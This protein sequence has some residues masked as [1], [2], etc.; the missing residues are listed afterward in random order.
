MIS[1]SLD[2]TVMLPG[3]ILPYESVVL[4]ARTAG[5][6]EQVLVDRGSVVKKGQLLVKLSAPE[7]AA[8]VAEAESKVQ[9][10]DSQRAEAEAQLASAQS[11]YDKLKTAAAT[12]GAIAGN[13]LVQAE[14]TVDAAKALARSREG[15]VRAA[16]ALVRAAKSMEEYL[17]LTAPFS[18]VITQRFVHPG[19]LVG[20]GTAEGLLELQQVSRL[21]LVVAVPEANATAIARG[22]RVQF[23]VPASPGQTFSGV[24]A[25]ISRALDPKTRTM[26]VELDVQNGRGLLAPGMYPQV[27]WPVHTQGAVLLVPST[28]V[29]TTTER[30]F[31]IRVRNGRAEWVNV[32]RG[33]AAGDLVQVLGTVQAGDLVVRRGTD[34][35]REGS[36]I[37][38]RAAQSYNVK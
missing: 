33:A 14:K 38:A 19:A 8:Q 20:P 30:T 6:V 5:Y 26:P 7:M 10:A 22:G 9:E 17:N 23:T 16:Q 35:I 37:Q 31:V 27:S 12:P 18:G 25:R 3:E 2:R 24:V 15:A 32:K 29:V 36:A 34:E 21:R 28:S 13:E 1:R 11:T 4:H